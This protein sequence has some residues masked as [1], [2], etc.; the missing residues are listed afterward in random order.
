[1]TASPTLF[2]QFR[3]EIERGIQG[4]NEGLEMGFDRIYDYVCGI[5]HSR[6]DLIGGDTGSGKTAFVD[7]AYL[8]NPYDRLNR[9]P[10][11]IK[12]SVL[13][14]SLEIPASRKITKLV[15]WKLQRDY[16]ILTD[17]NLILSRGKK[18]RIPKE[19]YDKI[20]ETQ[21][22]FDTMEQTVLNFRDNKL[23]PAGFYR[24]VMT[25]SEQHGKWNVKRDSEGNEIGK[26]YTPNDPFTYHIV[27]I[28]HL[29]MLANKEDMD[30]V[31][32][33]LVWFRNKC[34]FSPVVVS[35]YNRV[36]QSTDR[37]KL[38][39]MEPRLGDFKQTGN[40][41]ED[42]DT[43]IALFSPHRYKIPKYYGYDIQVLKNRL[44]TAHLLKNRDG[45]EGKVIP[46]NFFGEI[47][48][49]REFPK[50]DTVSKQTYEAALDIN[51]KF[52]Y[53]KQNFSAGQVGYGQ[54]TLD[55]NFESEDDSSNMSRPKGLAF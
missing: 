21:E 19:L 8:L 36:I 45:D 2:D 9:N 4:H 38:N 53:G 5:Q 54:I 31:S 49:F 55:Q 25:Y 22:Y 13:Y 11:K 14:F 28:D 47:G 17:V 34:G 40:T 1:M 51:K 41:Q 44:R 43:V 26:E 42:A 18:N 46:L 33:E 29:T 37:V 27:I 52:I 32:S 48:F 10:G 20:L 50:E 7:S 6:Y 3:N 23:T 12:M 16:G 15:A 24:D 35:Q 39:M 30:K